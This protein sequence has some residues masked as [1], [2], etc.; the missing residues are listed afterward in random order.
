MDPASATYIGLLDSPR[1]DE[2][3]E[4]YLTESEDGE[5]RIALRTIARSGLGWYPQKT[6]TIYPAQLQSLEILVKRARA[7]LARSSAVGSAE[8]AGDPQVIQ[9]PFFGCPAVA[10]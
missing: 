8:E 10:D 4:M 7:L 3:I 5:V 6:L 2:K 9:L 1:E